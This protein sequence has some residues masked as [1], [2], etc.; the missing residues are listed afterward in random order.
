MKRKVLEEGM[1]EVEYHKVHGVAVEDNDDG[2]YLVRYTPPEA[3]EYVVEASFRG[4]FGGA[5]GVLRGTPAM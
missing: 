4:T 5:A 3:G 2:S 1:E